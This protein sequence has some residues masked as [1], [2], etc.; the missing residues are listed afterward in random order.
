[1]DCVEQKPKEFIYRDNLI[2]LFY[3]AALRGEI[4]QKDFVKAKEIINRA[5]QYSTDDVGAFARR[6]NALKELA[7]RRN[8]Y[9]G[10]IICERHFS[11]GSKGTDSGFMGQLSY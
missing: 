3:N 10:R 8:Q 4:S 2:W 11:E 5:A 1:M 9:C 6:R 7:E